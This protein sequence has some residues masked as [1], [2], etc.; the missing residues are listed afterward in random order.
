MK[1][2]APLAALFVL[3]ASPLRAQTPAPAADPAG[4]GNGTGTT[5]P[6]DAKTAES[7]GP[8]HFWQASVPGGNY[9]VAIDRISSISMQTYMLDAAVVVHE[10]TIDTTGQALARFYYI[11]PPVTPS[12]GANQL[13]DRGRQVVDQIGKRTGNDSGTMVVK[14]Y[15]ET[16]HAKT[17]EY[18]LLS[19][20]ELDALYKSLKDTWET[21][22]GRRFTV[23]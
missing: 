12:G 23:K 11:E 10:V 2:L 13:I 18:R 17:V 6:T 22:R 16:T 4:N 20:T 19:E 1:V 21:G 15:P 9:M 7:D 5:N 3:F 14:K 8:R